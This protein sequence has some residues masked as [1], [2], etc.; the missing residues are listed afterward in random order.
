MGE[1]KWTSEV[2]RLC[3]KLRINCVNLS[4]Y[5]RRRYY[6][7]KSY[8][9]YFRLPLIILASINSTASVGLQP[10]LDQAYIS[11]LTCFIGMLMGI[12]GAV[13]LY[14]GIQSSMELELKQSKDFYTLAIDI[15]KTLQ[16]KPENR[17]EN[18]KD[19][20]NKKYGV[21]TK[22][23]EASNLLKRKLTADLLTPIPPKYVDRTRGVTPIEVTDSNGDKQVVLKDNDSWIRYIQCCFE[24]Q[25]VPANFFHDHDE[26]LQLYDFSKDTEPYVPDS[27]L[28]RTPTDKTPDYMSDYYEEHAADV[29]NQYYNNEEI[30]YNIHEELQQEDKEKVEAKKEDKEKVEAKKEDKETDTDSDK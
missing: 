1:H 23:C 8:G 27:P 24:V 26:N 30:I 5:H 2:E 20:L 13:E 28:V 4:E 6:H 25:K 3:E 9:K 19:Y 29:E 22:L 11:G 10:I 12:L 16:L 7:F 21:Y 17:G 15:Y 14:L 18:G